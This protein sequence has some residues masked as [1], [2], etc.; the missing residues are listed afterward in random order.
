MPKLDWGGSGQRLYETGVDRGVLYINGLGIAWNGLTG[1]NQASSGGTPTPYYLDG[2]KYLNVISAEDFEATIQAL[3]SPPEFAA[4]DGTMAIQ[5]G[6]F[7]TQQKRKV[8]S[9]SYRTMLGNDVKATDY[10]Y[11]LHLVYNALASPT[12][13]SNASMGDSTTPNALSWAITTTPPRIPG[14]KPTAHLV[15]DST[16]TPATILAMLENVLYGTELESPRIPSID[17]LFTLFS[18]YQQ[19]QFPEIQ[20]DN[21]VDTLTLDYVESPIVPI[22]QTGQQVIWMDT[23]NGT[24]GAVNLV[25]G[26]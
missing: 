14:Y 5:N 9:F 3:N 2:I 8:F 17:E 24:P 7:I 26:D 25:T 13:Y 1:V 22:L 15:V 11:K 20:D 21:S 23:S 12:A 18:D 16:K 10:G 19:I 4:C 6:L